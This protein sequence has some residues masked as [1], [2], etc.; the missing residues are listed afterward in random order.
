MAIFV[1]L[2][3][4]S[5]LDWIVEQTPTF[6]AWLERRKQAADADRQLA[7]DKQRIADFARDAAPP[8]QPK[9]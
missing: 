5:V 6:M 8:D 4:T 2:I 1:R 3:V 9:P 7:V